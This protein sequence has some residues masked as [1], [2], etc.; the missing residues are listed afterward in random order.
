MQVFKIGEKHEEWRGNFHIARTRYGA[1]WVCRSRWNSTLRWVCAWRCWRAP[2]LDGTIAIPKRFEHAQ[3]PNTVR[4]VILPINTEEQPNSSK[5]KVAERLA[6]L[7][8]IDGLLEGQ[9]VS[10]DSIKSERQARR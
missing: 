5:V 9:L 2:I 6:A 1:N 7:S 3:F 4:V 8:R 10:V